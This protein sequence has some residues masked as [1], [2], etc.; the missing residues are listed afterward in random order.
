MP[1]LQGGRGI[2][3]EG[4]LPMRS[5]LETIGSDGSTL[6]ALASSTVGGVRC[7]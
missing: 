6:T 5:Q 1:S 7:G 2:E 3:Y 4:E